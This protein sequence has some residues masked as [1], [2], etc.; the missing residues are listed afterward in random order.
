MLAQS[1]FEATMECAVESMVPHLADGAAV[2]LATE[3]GWERLACAHVNP[4]KREAMA[5][6]LASYRP[7]SGERHPLAA[8]LIEG[9]PQLH[10]P[11][12][13][14]QW[15]HEHVDGEAGRLLRVLE[16]RSVLVVPFLGEHASA[17][18]LVL[19]DGENSR[20]LGAANVTLAQEL[21]DLVCRSLFP[22]RLLEAARQD[23]A[24]ETRAIGSVVHDLRTPLA[25]IKLRAEVTA[26]ALDASRQPNPRQAMLEIAATALRMAQM[27]G[28]VLDFVQLQSGQRLVL[29][30]T[31]VD[32]NA[33]VSEVVDSYRGQFA[34]QIVT[35]IAPPSVTGRWDEPRIRRVLD[36]LVQNAVKY[37]PGGGTISVTVARED[38]DAVIAVEDQGIGIP[39]AEL[40]RS[41]EWFH[42]ASNVQTRIPGTGMGLAGAQSIVDLHHGTISLTSQEGQGTRVTVRIPL[43]PEEAA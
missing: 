20:Q 19:L 3:G 16:P 9:K 38:S 28:E 4:G 34:G 15:T 29:R 21:A 27:L 40:G 6:W 13:A 10:S 37:S 26:R 32:L 33:L 17:G 2:A 23:L 7:G 42:R 35:P 24:A 41:F 8:A 43:Q 1:N 5:R 25:A 36:N 22:W 30:Y 14:R 11:F 18:L 39:A 31:N 12:Q